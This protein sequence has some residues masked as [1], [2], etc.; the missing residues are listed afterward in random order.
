MM[1]S[2]QSL[3][4]IVFAVALIMAPMLFTQ[5][6]ALSLLSQM[7]TMMLLCLSYNMLLGQGGMLSF[8]HAVYSGLGAFIA[9]H[10]MNR[11]TGDTFALPVV[12]IPLVGGLAGMFFGMVFGY[13]TTKRAGTTFAM[14]TLGIA[15][16]VSAS[17]L[18]FPDFFGGESGVST[19]RVIGPGLMG[20]TFG[21][22]IEVYYLICFWLFVS[23]LVMFYFTK[24]PL[25]RM[26]N[27]VRDNPQRA[28]FVGYDPQKVRYLTLMVA[29]FFAGVSGGLSAINFEIVSAENLSVV[30]S[31][32]ILLFT[33]I[34]GI[35]YF[36]G[37]VI[38]AAIGVFFSGLLSGY[39][40]AWQLYLGCFFIVTVMFMP[41]GVTRLIEAHWQMIKTGKLRRVWAAWLA[42]CSL[43]V[44][45]VMAFVGCVEMLY[46]VTVDRAAEPV[47]TFAHLTID[48]TSFVSWVGLL[49]VMVVAVY[50]MSKLLP[51]VR[52]H[53][54]TREGV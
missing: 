8:G 23:A 9:V 39:T 46:V 19:D 3:P 52:Q 13:V 53:W 29:A 48:A 24:T 54:Q 18:M 51:R 11:L 14:I 45:A 16:L 44:I 26:M 31:G 38:G 32:T 2:K 36:F 47:I 20:V 1:Q 25:G 35:G 10:V 17:A 34:G 42:T 15:E 40:K 21:P 7:G 5:D 4:W 28:A 6:S 33:Y 37:P 30:R 27:A 50:G 41:G 12:F 49:S 43:L 22:Q